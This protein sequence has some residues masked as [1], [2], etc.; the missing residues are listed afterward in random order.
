MAAA[1]LL[2]GLHF[3]GGP[4]GDAGLEIRAG[5]RYHGAGL[6]L[7]RAARQSHFKP[8]RAFRV[9][10]QQ[11][12]SAQRERIRRARSGDAQVRVSGAPEI[13]DGGQQAG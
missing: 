13:L 4:H 5:Q 8:G 11:V 12:A 10:D 3:D 6:E 1:H 2:A 9:T 7:E